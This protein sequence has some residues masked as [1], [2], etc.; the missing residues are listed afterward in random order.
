MPLYCDSITDRI[1][2]SNNA[3]WGNGQKYS[4]L[5]WFYC[6]DLSNTQSLASYQWDGADRYRI[7]IAPA[8]DKIGV[9]HYIAGD[10][11]TAESSAS[12]LTINKWTC[13]CVTTDGSLTSG[14]IKI[15]IGTLGGN[16][17]AD[18]ATEGDTLAAGASYTMGNSFWLCNNDNSDADYNRCPVAINILL[19]GIILTQGQFQELMYS[20]QNCLKYSETVMY[21]LVGMHGVSSVVDLSGSGNDGTG[22]GMIQYAD[23][24]PIKPLFG[25]DTYPRYTPAAPSGVVLF[26]R[27]RAG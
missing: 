15:Y 16:L 13:V 25:F 1:E 8:T 11:V 26:R 3:N 27:R 6:N 12:S 14:A 22:T 2:I 24:V 17:G 7:Q 18:D 5:I 4:Q 9:Y 23:N 19:N 21:H 10:D 20:P